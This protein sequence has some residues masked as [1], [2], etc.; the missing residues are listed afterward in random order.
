MSKKNSLMKILRKKKQSEWWGVKK[1]GSQERAAIDKELNNVADGME[2]EAALTLIAKAGIVS[3]RKEFCVALVRMM[4]SDTNYVLT[5]NGLWVCGKIRTVAPASVFTLLK[6]KLRRLNFATMYETHF[7]WAVAALSNI[8]PP[9]VPATVPFQIVR[10]IVKNQLSGLTVRQIGILY[11]G[12][13]SMEKLFSSE[14]KV[15]LREALEVRLLSSNGTHLIRSMSFSTASSVLEWLGKCAV[16]EKSDINASIATQISGRIRTL[17]GPSRLMPNDYETFRIDILPP[18]VISRL[19]W[20]FSFSPKEA[21]FDIQPAISILTTSAELIPKHMFKPLDIVL[22]LN[23]L[24]RMKSNIPSAFTYFGSLFAKY[25]KRQHHKTV[26][27]TNISTVLNAFALA[28]ASN[29][30]FDDIYTALGDNKNV[31]LKEKEQNLV[32]VATL[33]LR[34][35]AVLNRWKTPKVTELVLS[36]IDNQFRSG[37]GDLRDFK[38]TEESLVTIGLQVDV[39]NR[40]EF[41]S[42]LLRKMVAALSHKCFSDKI[43]STSQKL[44]FLKSCLDAKSFPTSTVMRKLMP[45]LP[46]LLSSSDLLV[47]LHCCDAAGGIS[48]VRE[49]LL[50][51]RVSSEYSDIK[52]TCELITFL[53][54]D[55]GSRTHSLIPILLSRVVE[56]SQREEVLSLRTCQSMLIAWKKILSQQPLGKQQVK[57]Y[58]NLTKIFYPSIANI[59][60]HATQ[61]DPDTAS[62]QVTTVKPSPNKQPKSSPP[63]PVDG[64]LKSKPPVDL[65]LIQPKQEIALKKKNQLAGSNHQKRR[66]QKPPDNN[67]NNNIGT[68]RVRITDDR[69]V[70][71]PSAAIQRSLVIQ[72]QQVAEKD[73]TQSQ[74]QKRTLNNHS[75]KPRAAVFAA[76]NKPPQENNYKPVPLPQQKTLSQEEELSIS[77]IASLEV[78][79]LNN[80][81]V[82]DGTVRIIDVQQLYQIGLRLIPK[83]EEGFAIKLITCLLRNPFWKPKNLLLS[84]IYQLSLSRETSTEINNLFLALREWGGQRECRLVEHLQV[85]GNIPSN[86]SRARVKVRSP[87]SVS[88]KL[89]RNDQPLAAKV[90]RSQLSLEPNSIL[91]ELQILC[92]ATLA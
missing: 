88:S 27:A 43:I 82:I 79:Y 4:S 26:T 29:S 85:V 57:E 40:D 83:L 35:S 63:L 76:S 17:S 42:T 70:V 84:S 67:N 73:R 38:R 11:A 60:R 41:T 24:G 32:R 19:M 48:L 51:F 74:S 1:I 6:L 12:L 15:Q 22:I 25:A 58:S 20:G 36:I 21:L 65:L 33:A 66:Y 52:S 90:P 56:L 34:A 44:S 10:H 3:E 5:S 8:N 14:Q 45:S 81:P 54:D 39:S 2:A 78:L 68:L 55:P 91:S 61:P 18:T 80:G 50:Y 23:S 87:V 46:R 64:G 89:T 13:C 69:K 9:H 72:Q 62:R 53:L 31:Y 59:L 16:S 49:A 7:V 37:S 71:F 75:V 28:R 30:Q 77:V 92:N 47:I 86:I